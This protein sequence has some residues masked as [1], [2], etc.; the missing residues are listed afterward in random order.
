MRPAYNKFEIQL[1]FISI[2][3]IVTKKEILETWAKLAV[4]LAYDEN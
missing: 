4:L 2:T 1:Y 3:I